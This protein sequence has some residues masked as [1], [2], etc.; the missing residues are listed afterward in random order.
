MI[1]IT[2]MIMNMIINPDSVHVLFTNLHPSNQSGL[3]SHVV[4][5]PANLAMGQ[6][7]SSEV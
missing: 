4:I 6:V 7:L 1:V 5:G 2:R 3:F